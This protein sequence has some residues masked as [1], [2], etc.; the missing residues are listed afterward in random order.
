MREEQTLGRGLNPRGPYEPVKLAAG[1]EVESNR[2]FES[3][4][5]ITEITRFGER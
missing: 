2:V 4:N 3:E 5:V 1:S